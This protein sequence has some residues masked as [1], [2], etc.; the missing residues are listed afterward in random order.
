MKHVYRLLTLLLLALLSPAITQATTPPGDSL[1]VAL[2]HVF[3][4]LD[5]SQVPTP[6]LQDYGYKF[7]SLTPYNGTLT[8]S[9][10]S[11]LVVWRQ[12]YASLLSGG[13]PGRANYLPEPGTFN[14]ELVAQLSA[15]GEAIPL[16]V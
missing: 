1:R 12:L 5:L 4:P 8:D 16:L 10:V 15:S 6:Y 2:D 3:A 11:S 14:Q 13:L 7:V 9:S